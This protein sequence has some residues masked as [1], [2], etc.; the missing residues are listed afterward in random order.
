MSKKQTESTILADEV[1]GKS[2]AFVIKYK[3][4]FLGTILAI[5][6]IVVGYLAYSHYIA[7]P[8]EV[9]ANN[10]IFKAEQYFINGDFETALNG[11]GINAGF[12]QVIEENGGTDAAN[13]AYAYA[14]ICQ[15]QLG[16]FDEAIESL[17]EYDG[18]D[19]IVAP[20]VK[21]ALGNCYAQKENLDKAIKLVLEAAEDA[22]NITVTPKCLFDAAAMYEK[23][24]KND[25][26]IELYNRIKTEYPQS[27]EASGIDRLINA[28]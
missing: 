3:N 18:D 1:L 8:K 2:E 21:Y 5:V 27:P 13:L 7:E 11:D 16:N 19:K 20:M 4:A 10:A 14:G 6:A 26:A 9:A 25:K 17:E 15:A 12:L 23:Q 22:E 28:K 24:G